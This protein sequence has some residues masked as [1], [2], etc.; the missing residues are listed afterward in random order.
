MKAVRRGAALQQRALLVTGT[1]LY[2]TAMN[3]CY[4]LMTIAAAHALCEL[5]IAFVHEK[6]VAHGKLAANA[7]LLGDPRF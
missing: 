1:R 3:C 2:V 6:P 5:M 4:A 7:W